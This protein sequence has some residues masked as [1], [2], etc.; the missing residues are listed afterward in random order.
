MAARTTTRENLAFE[1]VKNKL[2]G[3][4]K[5][6]GGNLSKPSRTK[7]NAGITELIRMI[8]KIY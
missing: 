8:E 2:W 6:L 1:T 4:L 5:G 3:F 7:K